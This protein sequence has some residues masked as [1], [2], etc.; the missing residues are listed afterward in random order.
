M[1][2]SEI[3]EEV[4]M[5]VKAIRE[6]DIEVPSVTQGLKP[7]L[8][9]VCVFYMIYVVSVIPIFF[10]GN[11][12]E[13]ET[14]SAF[15]CIS[16]LF[17]L[18]FALVIYSIYIQVLNIPEEVRRKSKLFLFVKEKVCHYACFHFGLLL[19]FSALS[20][21]SGVSGFLPF[22][23]VPLFIITFLVFHIDLSR[24]NL[25]SLAG[26][27]DAAK[28]EFKNNELQEFLN[29]VNKEKK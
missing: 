19:T 11:S 13:I 3:R 16:I 25:P 10:F 27:V 14:A 21:A 29:G 20:L 6:T 26:L 4:S 28:H 15:F 12:N 7:S 24:F 17:N 18:F 5:I 8:V 23:Q 9:Y 22:V 1:K 2:Q